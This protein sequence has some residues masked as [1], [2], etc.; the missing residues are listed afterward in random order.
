MLFGMSGDRLVEQT[1]DRSS[2][3]VPKIDRDSA[4]MMECARGSGT[5]VV[6]SSR[7]MLTASHVVAGG[8]T[9]DIQDPLRGGNTA[10]LDRDDA[11][12]D[13][14]TMKGRFRAKPVE[15]NCDGFTTGETYY[16]TGHPYGKER[17]TVPAVA[18][19]RYL[20]TRPTNGP[21]TKRLRELDGSSF[22]GMSGGPIMDDQGRVVGVVSSRP[23]DDRSVTMAKE[24]RDTFI[25]TDK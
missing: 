14:A 9:C 1:A 7:T 18:T 19:P 12:N 17:I 15:V 13:F 3:T 21:P 5:G 10:T 2:I 6:I 24:L 8:H 23:V 20:D 4:P 11:S 22:P 25:C 16:M